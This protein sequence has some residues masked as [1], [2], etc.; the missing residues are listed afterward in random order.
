MAVSEDLMA[1]GRAWLKEFC[2]VGKTK[3]TVR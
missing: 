3:A 2:D 1:S